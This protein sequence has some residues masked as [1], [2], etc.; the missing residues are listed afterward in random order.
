MDNTAVKHYLAFFKGERQIGSG[1][2][3]V[4][5]GGRYHQYGHG[6]GDVLRGAFRFIFPLAARGV[7]TFLNHTANAH[8]K[9]ADLKTAAKTAIGPTTRR[10]VNTAFDNEESNYVPEFSR[11]NVIR[12]RHPIR[13]RRNV[14]RGKQLGSG[15]GGHKGYKKAK[16]RRA[17]Y[18]NWNF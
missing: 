2:F 14:V 9:G 1:D 16:K 13:S 15:I 7:S 3:P 18:T 11:R 6:F 8:A 4:F 5:K 12:R 10:V 17:D